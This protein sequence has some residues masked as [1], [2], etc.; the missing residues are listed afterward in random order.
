MA[1][2]LAAFGGEMAALFAA[3]EVTTS[4]SSRNNFSNNNLDTAR[5]ASFRQ[6]AD[7]GAPA[8]RAG[9]RPDGAARPARTVKGPG[10]LGA[11]R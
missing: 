1:E 9:C 11:V 5:R 7:V 10:R 2:I 4:A 8:A 3:V 6:S